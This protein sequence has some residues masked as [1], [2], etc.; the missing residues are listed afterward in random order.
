MCDYSVLFTSIV[1]DLHVAKKPSKLHILRGVIRFYDVGDRTVKLLSLQYASDHLSLSPRKSLVLMPGIC[2]S[3]S[4][5]HQITFI[6][7]QIIVERHCFHDNRSMIDIQGNSGAMLW[8]THLGPIYTGWSKQRQVKL[9]HRSKMIT[10]TIIICDWRISQN[11]ICVRW[12]RRNSVSVRIPSQ[13]P[14]LFK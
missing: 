4:I 1:T 6:S 13:L 10:H 8:I 5:I 12:I 7:F 14:L 11:L 2:I 3:W 9:S